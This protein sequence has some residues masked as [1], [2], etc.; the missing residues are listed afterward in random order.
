MNKSQ[1]Y[2]EG[3][4]LIEEGGLQGGLQMVENASEIGS[5]GEIARE[6]AERE[7]ELAAKRSQGDDDCD[8]PL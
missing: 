3:R 8:L 4:E 1:L 7:A 5:A 6:D 2:K